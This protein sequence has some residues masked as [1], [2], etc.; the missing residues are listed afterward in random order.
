MPYVRLSLVLNKE[1]IMGMLE[2]QTAVVFECIGGM[3]VVD[4]VVPAPGHKP[5]GSFGWC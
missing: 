3:V 4:G 2:K 5:P 1:P